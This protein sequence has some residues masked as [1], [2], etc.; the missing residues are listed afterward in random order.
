M[1][2][3]TSAV[4]AML[5]DEPEQAAITRALRTAAIRRISAGSWIELT[6]VLTRRADPILRK[7]LSELLELFPLE[8]APVT[9]EQAVIGETGYRTFGQASRHPA[10]LN[11]GDCFAYA[12]AKATGEPLLFKGDDFVHTDITAA[13]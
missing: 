10:R 6:V 4:M 3:D 11:F 2:V 5:L 13:L 8:I 12:L 1:I 9:A 7:K